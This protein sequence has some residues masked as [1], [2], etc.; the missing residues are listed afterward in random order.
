MICKWTKT[1]SEYRVCSFV[2]LVLGLS[3][4]IALSMNLS[5]RKRSSLVGNRMLSSS[6][7]AIRP[8]EIAEQDNH[9]SVESSSV[10]DTP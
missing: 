9:E 6:Y 3:P 2:R 10:V 7:W 1:A 8:H 5:Q 4:L